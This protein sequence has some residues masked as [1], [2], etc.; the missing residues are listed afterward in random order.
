MIAVSCRDD[1]EQMR[2]TRWRYD[3]NTDYWFP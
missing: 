1:A 3:Y 2:L